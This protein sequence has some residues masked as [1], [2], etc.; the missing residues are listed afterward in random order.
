MRPAG[1]G[2]ARSRAT[3]KAGLASRAAPISDAGR[4]SEITPSKFLTEEKRQNS[5]LRVGDGSSA[6]SRRASVRAST[7]H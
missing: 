2:K 6:N 1:S 4:A 3:S 7:N 5:S